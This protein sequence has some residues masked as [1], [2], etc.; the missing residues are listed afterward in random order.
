M[1]P[2]VVTLR[3]VEERLL[4]RARHNARTA[5]LADRERARAR[6]AAEARLGSPRP[7]DRVRAAGSDP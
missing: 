2:L 4:R 7:V 1:S 3:A 5:L 6:R